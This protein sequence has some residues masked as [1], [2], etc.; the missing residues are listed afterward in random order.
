VVLFLAPV[1]MLYYI[2]RLM[3]VEP[4]LYPWKETNLVMV[5]DL[6]NVLLNSACQYGQNIFFLDLI[7]LCPQTLDTHNGAQC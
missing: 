3:Y 1:Y 6:F 7:F 2:Y 5:Y 4:S